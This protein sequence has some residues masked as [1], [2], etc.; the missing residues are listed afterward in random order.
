MNKDAWGAD[1]YQYGS[2]EFSMLAEGGER[3]QQDRT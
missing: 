3:G 1:N 2:E